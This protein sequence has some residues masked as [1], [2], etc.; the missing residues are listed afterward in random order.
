VS[1]CLM[2]TIAFPMGPVTV[3][4]CETKDLQHRHQRWERSSSLWGDD[5]RA[6]ARTARAPST[7]RRVHD[8][9][10]IGFPLLSSTDDTA[11]VDS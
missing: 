11:F 9:G 3:V 2:P 7:A 10:D 5:C 8:A 6:N 4:T 1:R